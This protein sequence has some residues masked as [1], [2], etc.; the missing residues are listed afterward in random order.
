MLAIS[1]GIN[2]PITIA[3]PDGTITIVI[4]NVVSRSP[5]GALL[6]NPRIGIG[7]DAPKNFAIHRDDTKVKR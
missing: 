2:E 4:T 6:S 1:R 7:I 3:T 5:D